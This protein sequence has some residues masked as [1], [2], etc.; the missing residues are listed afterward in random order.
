MARAARSESFPLPLPTKLLLTLPPPHKNLNN[1]Q[2]NPDGKWAEAR[3]L[4]PREGENYKIGESRKVCRS[5]W[6]VIQSVKTGGFQVKVNQGK[7]KLLC[8]KSEW[9]KM[10]ESQKWELEERFK[11]PNPQKSWVNESQ[12]QGQSVD[13][14]EQSPKHI[15]HPPYRVTQH[16]VD[17]MHHC[18]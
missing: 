5:Y 15:V 9:S 12:R 18:V 14:I 10:D 13:Q 6:C 11:T 8:S 1:V 3:G 16:D 4:V 17:T 7:L 2:S